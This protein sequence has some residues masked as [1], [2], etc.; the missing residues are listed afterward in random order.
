M[1]N[2]YQWTPEER[3]RREETTKRLE[4][5][6]AAYWAAR[7]PKA[8]KRR[9]AT[10]KAA[11]KR[12]ARKAANIRAA[13]KAEGRAARANYMAAEGIVW[14]RAFYGVKIPAT[15]LSPKAAAR[16]REEAMSAAARA[17]ARWQRGTEG[18][19]LKAA[20]DAEDSL[21]DGLI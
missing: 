7:Y 3:A 5:E 13:V 17:I 21:L 4:A 20:A 1:E 15:Q 6:S 10:A 12:K 18:A 14:S 9:A 2:K 11:A 8:A 16:N 19:R